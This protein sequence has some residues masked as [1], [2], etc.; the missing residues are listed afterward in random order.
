[1]NIILHDSN[2]VKCFFAVFLVSLVAFHLHG[3][4]ISPRGEFGP[5]KLVKP[6]NFDGSA[7]YQA[8]KVSGHVFVC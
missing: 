3:R 6:H 8:R 7:I 4:I 1:M 5:I 2:F